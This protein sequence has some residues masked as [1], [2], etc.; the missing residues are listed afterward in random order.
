MIDHSRAFRTQKTL[1]DPKALSIC[2]RNLLAKMKALTAANIEKVMKNDLEKGEIQ[3]L[4]VRR[5]LMVK[6]F[7]SKGDGALYDR[8]SRN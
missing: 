1:L 2:D 4:L 7:E 6:F 5:D 3:G 8:P